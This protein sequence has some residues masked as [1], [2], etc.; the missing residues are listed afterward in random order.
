[1]PNCPKCQNRLEYVAGDYQTGV[2][3][4]DGY[5]ESCYQ[6]GFYCERCNQYYDNTDLD[7]LVAEGNDP[8]FMRPI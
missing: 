8:E 2:V 7:D 6:E 3:A 5:R 4:P 1:M